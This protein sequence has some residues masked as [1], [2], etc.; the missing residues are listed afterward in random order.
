M[1]PFIRIGIVDDHPMLREGV[2]NTL[3]KRADLQVVEQGA[4]AQYAR[5]IAQRVRPDVMLNDKCA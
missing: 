2:A 4:N 1:S 3:K 5:D